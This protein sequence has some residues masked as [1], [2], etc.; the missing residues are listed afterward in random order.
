MM[1]VIEVV[2]VCVA[3]ILYHNYNFLCVTMYIHLDGKACGN[4]VSSE[5]WA[6]RAVCV[7]E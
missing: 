7:C 3:Y 6:F 4:R 5:L 1:V 2:L